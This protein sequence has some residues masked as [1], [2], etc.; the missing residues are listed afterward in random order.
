MRKVK[1]PVVTN[2][3][4]QTRMK[5]TRRFKNKSDFAFHNSWVCVGGEKYSDTCKS[6]GGAPHVC[7]NSADKW[8]QVGALAWGMGCGATPAPPAVYSSIADGMCWI[9]WVMSC[10]PDA[11]KTTSVEHLEGQGSTVDSRNKLTRTTCGEW[12]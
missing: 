8:V 5:K 4:C 6:V 2:E 7:K 12:L 10:V 9:D 11:D 3:E 1:M